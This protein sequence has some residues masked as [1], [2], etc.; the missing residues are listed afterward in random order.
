MYSEEICRQFYDLFKIPTISL[1][2]FSAYGEGL[3][4]QLFW[5]LY[6]KMD[7]SDEEIE[8]FGTGAESR[9]FIYIRDIVQAIGC[10]LNNA[11]F[12]GN[13][14]NIATGVESTIHKAVGCFIKSSNR[15]LKV[16]FAGNTKI[17]DPL[18]WQA[19]ISLLNSFGFR[20]KFS[21]EQGINNYVEWLQGKRSL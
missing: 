19:D 9:D 8:L 16:R 1:R 2:I 7:S 15:N 3:K 14:I 6:K 11:E 21:L 5:D 13:A 20:Q 17:G 4:K 18:N 12:K 10:I